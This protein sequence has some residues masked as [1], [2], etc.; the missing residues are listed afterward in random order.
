VS[1]HTLAERVDLLAYICSARPSWGL[2]GWGLP[3]WGWAAHAA[4]GLPGREQFGENICFERRL[5]N[6]PLLVSGETELVPCS[7]A[8]IV[9]ELAV[10]FS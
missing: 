5:R 10:V 2:P 4:S 7:L 8:I 9:V 6:I 1:A 3:G